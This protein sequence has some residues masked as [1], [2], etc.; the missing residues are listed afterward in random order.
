MKDGAFRLSSTPFD[1]NET[2]D[3]ICN[4]FEPQ[5]QFKDVQLIYTTADDKQLPKLIGDGKRFQ[6]VVIN[7]VR[8]SMKFTLYGSIKIKA[9]YCSERSLIKVS[10]TDTGS[11]IAA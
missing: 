11:G 2:F 10:V 8:N 5:L 7:L 4:S 1:P 3:L 9:R 6:Q